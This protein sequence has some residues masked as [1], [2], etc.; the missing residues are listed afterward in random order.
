MGQPTGP[1]NHHGVKNSAECWRTVE[2]VRWPQWRCEPSATIIAAYRAKGIRFRK[3]RHKDGA[4]DLFVHPEDHA[5][6]TIVDAEVEPML[7]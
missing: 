6:A 2:G 5:V 3:V 7:G 1:R 4:T